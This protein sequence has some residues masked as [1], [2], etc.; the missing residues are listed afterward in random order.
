[1]STRTLAIWFVIALIAALATA[2]YRGAAVGL[3]LGD[4]SLFCS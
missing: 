1:M 3:L 2:A 4:A